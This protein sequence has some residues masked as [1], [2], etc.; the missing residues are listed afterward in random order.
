MN[1]N[2]DILERIVFFPK[3]NLQTKLLSFVLLFSLF[4]INA[5]NNKS[6]KKAANLL[7]LNEIILE[8]ESIQKQV[9]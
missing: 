3:I 5:N 4:Q 8:K 9:K 2:L 1:K 6:L 7:E